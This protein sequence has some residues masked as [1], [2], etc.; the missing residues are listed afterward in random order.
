LIE[1]DDSD[2]VFLVEPTD[3]Y[4]FLSAFTEGECH[5]D[6]VSEGSFYQKIKISVFQPLGFCSPDSLGPILTITKLSTN[7]F[8]VDLSINFGSTEY[9]IEAT[10]LYNLFSIYGKVYIYKDSDYFPDDALYGPLESD[11]FFPGPIE[12][13]S[14]C[15]EQKL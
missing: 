6:P 12:D 9:N 8:F 5:E 1:Q 15:L 2:Y 10:R 11:L 14:A 7:S 3:P 4:L 13:L